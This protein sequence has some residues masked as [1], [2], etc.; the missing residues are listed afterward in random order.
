M[1]KKHNLFV[2]EGPSGVGK[3]SFTSLL[4]TRLSDIGYNVKRFD[5]YL[6]IYNCFCAK[7][8]DAFLKKASPAD[9][10]SIDPRSRYLLMTARQIDIFKNEVKPLL[11]SGVILLFDRYWWSSYIF[12]RVLGMEESFMEPLYHIYKSVSSTMPPNII[13]NFKRSES[14]KADAVDHDRYIEEYSKVVDREKDNHTIID[15]NNDYDMSIAVN[16]VTS[17][18]IDNLSTDS[19]IKHSREVVAL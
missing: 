15:I 12:G 19:S 2:F 8:I 3:T 6:S 10:K 11:D 18:I 4:E 1:S 13:F 14:L 7:N 17:Y 9:N 5:T 16:E